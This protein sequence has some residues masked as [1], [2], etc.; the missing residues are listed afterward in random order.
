MHQFSIFILTGICIAHYHKLI[1][2][3]KQEPKGN[4]DSRIKS[5][6]TE[7]NNIGQ[8]QQQLHLT[9]SRTSNTLTWASALFVACITF[10]VY[11]PALQNGFVNWDDHLYVFENQNILSISLGFLKW[12]LTG[13]VAGLWHPLTMFSL[14]LDYAIWGMEP[15]GFHLTNILFHTFNTFLVLILVV[16]L[17][18]CSGIEQDRF[19]KK[20]LVT[21]VVTALLFGI[22]P[23]H[24]ESVVWISERKDVLCA[25][26][27]LLSIL[28]YLKYF[29]T[30]RALFY[31]ASL[32]S[33]AMALMSKPMAVTLPI[34]LII[35]DFYPLKRWKTVRELKQVL[36]E[37]IPFFA[38]S[39]SAALITIWA[40]MSHGGIKTLE[41]FPLTTRVFV[42]VSAI[43]FYLLKMIMPVNLAPFYPYPK[44]VALFKLEYAGSLALFLLI[45][46][47]C[48]WIFKKKRLFSVIWLY[49][50]ATLI[51]VIGIL[52]VG[53]QAAADRYTYL[54]SLGPFLLVGVGVGTAFERCPRCRKAI[55]VFLL[56]LSGLLINKTV[57]QTTLWKDSITLWSYEIKL[58]PRVEIAYNSRGIAYSKLGD[59]LAAV[60]DYT[61]AIEINPG[62]AEAYFNRGNASYIGLG[63]YMQAIMD[64]TKAIEIDSEYA[65]AYSNRGSAYTK[66]G[67]YAQAIVNYNMAVKLNPRDVEAYYNRG[68]AYTELGNYAQAIAAYDMAIKLNPRHANAYISRGNVYNNLGDDAQAISDYTKAIEIN[69]TYTEAYYNRGNAYFALGNHQL[70]MKDY[71][72]TIELNPKYVRAYGNRGS[73]YNIFGHFQDAIKDYS[74][75]IELDPKDATAYKLRG[76]SYK[77]MGNYR[78]ARMDLRMAVELN[79]TDQEAHYNLRL[80]QD[81]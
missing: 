69:P 35:L 67:N 29:I 79:P 4:R 20:T 42:A 31:G 27:F 64:Y 15:W 74:K 40:H 18:E 21:G 49:Y 39:I 73:I 65:V 5:K 8:P 13:V 68:N 71:N 33:F 41:A 51:P 56:L 47:L 36:L 50:V 46:L 76:I 70:A 60:I 3:K 30:K 22:H 57:T 19:R 66:L 72:M 17:I 54:P 14:A 59:Y 78:Q 37:K 80:V 26:F 9:Y 10:I 55:A 7:K 43:I 12:S 1:V 44:D 62:Y 38:L 2:K 53:N 75:A 58:F 48:I 24:V 52:Q 23:L 77:N 61:K 32:M 6:N 45:T 81:R 11:L 63:N 28:A 16:R 34:V 25:L